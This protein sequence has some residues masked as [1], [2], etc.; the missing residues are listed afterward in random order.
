MILKF[1]HDNFE[2]DLVNFEFAMV[3]ENNWFTN[4]LFTK[5]TYPLDI[6]LTNDQD[7]ALGFISHQNIENRRSL[8]E[9]RFYVNGE[10]HD[11]VLE[12]EKILGSVI[13]A[14]VRY[15]F[16]ELP[17]G[18]KKLSD[19][20]L[21]DF[22]LLTSIFAYANTAINNTY[23]AVNFCFPKIWTDRI[24]VDN[25]QWQA[26]QGALNNYKNAG[27]LLNEYDNVNDVQINRN[28]VQPMPFLL[29]VLKKG[30]EDAGYELAGDIL[31][32]PEF[33]KAFIYYFSSYYSS[34]NNVSFA[35]SLNANQYQIL[36][37]PI[38]AKYFQTI[39]LPE[40]GR[41]K[42]AGNVF[43]R[44]K[45]GT[46]ST[47]FGVARANFQYNNLTVWDASFLTSQAYEE[48]I[49]SI[50]FNIN[51]YG[52]EGGLNFNS[53]NLPFSELSDIIDYEA[54][55]ADVTITQ[56][57]KFD[58]LGNILPSLIVPNQIKLNKCVPDITFGKLFEI[59]RIWKNFDLVLEDG[60]AKMNYINRAFNTTNAQSLK[61]FEVEFPEIYFNQGKSF[62]LKFQDINTDKYPEYLYPEV[63][64]NNNGYSQSP[65]TQPDEAEEVIIEAI[66]LPL[67]TVDGQISAH[68]FMDDKNS[69][70]IG[71]YNGLVAGNNRVMD[72]AP[73][74]ITAVFETYYRL[75]FEFLLKTLNYNWNFLSHPEKLQ[76]LKVKSVIYAYQNYF[77]I[78]RI[79]RSNVTPELI[80]TEIEAKTLI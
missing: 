48:K 54:V 58:S 31:T 57:T 5:Y 34:T 22:E 33:S 4:Q 72:P 71:L 19:L 61:D 55:I 41:Y 36:V 50:D 76:R 10:V 74:M 21:E 2:L 79:S 73:L 45:R 43:L 46:F 38:Y 65:F 18:N 63:L 56:L 47:L 17:N 26:F 66:P 13:T 64:I 15:G 37:N 1:I 30:F 27:M 60:F 75:W 59:C 40:P 24:D 25:E 80:Y 7:A 8:F 9:G 67:K 77:L 78:E 11:A 49:V 20:P 3:E 53:D 44:A 69:L 6:D 14:Q 42:L 52:T 28:I 23:P 68:D 70:F 32:D 35:F 12:I 51:F 29:H 39:I 16:E 62:V